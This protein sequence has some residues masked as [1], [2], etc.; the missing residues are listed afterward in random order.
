MLQKRSLIPGFILQKRSVVPRM[1][2]R[3]RSLIPGLTL[4]KSSLIPGFMLRKSS[5][6]PGFMLRV[7]PLI[8]ESTSLLTT[9]VAKNQ[10]FNFDFF[11]SE[12]ILQSRSPAYPQ[13]FFDAAECLSRNHPQ[14]F[15]P[16][17]SG[18][19]FT[20]ADDLIFCGHL[21]V[22]KFRGTV[23]KHWRHRYW[24]RRTCKYV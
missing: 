22:G 16:F 11:I 24:I 23:R 10:I 15:V 14:I 21:D 18:E 9:T 7:S 13:Y 3:E 4:R 6:V 1:M 20:L 8:G 17:L 5:L 19:F 2:L 12:S